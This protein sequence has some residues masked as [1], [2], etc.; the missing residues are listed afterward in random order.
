M[1]GGWGGRCRLAV[2]FAAV[3][4][5]GF[6]SA[7]SAR[8]NLD[9]ERALADVMMEPAEVGAPTFKPRDRDWAILPQ[10]GYSPEKGPNAGLK[11]V[12]R[13]L[14]AARL[15]LDI[16]GIYALKR[17]QKYELALVA[18]S[19]WKGR[20]I[21]I[22]QGQ[23]LFDP[24]KE[25]F[26]IGN[27]E[28]GPDPISTHEYQL[29]LGLVTLAARP[30]PRITFAL[31][32]GFNDVNVKPGELEDETPATTEVFPGLP[33]I[34]GGRTNPLAFSIVFN[35]REDVTRPTRGWSFTA[36]IQH[37]H[38]ELGN[39]FQFTRYILD[40]SYLRPL[41]TR[42]QVL[43]LRVAG[44]YIDAKKDEVPFYEFAALGGSADL[45]GYFHDRFLGTSR[46]MLNGEYRLKLFDFPFFDWWRVRID[47]VA[48]GDMGRVFSD[49]SE[50]RD[51][52]TVDG[53]LIP[54]VFRDFRYSYGGGARFALGDAIIARLDVGFSDEEDGLVYLTFGHTF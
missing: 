33:G 39:D 43:G 44:E 30:W 38:G 27:N 31:T 35:N 23:Y 28:V 42:R 6:V 22:V 54:R 52:F 1:R 4:V 17:Q 20:L 37:V 19:L 11:F 32:G 16:D 26:G 36:K 2:T 5:A 18:P 3:A 49:Q 34:H 51:E 50:F 14:T 13:D 41:L 15:T 7:T 10:I 8:E 40:A 48:F 46:V 29:V 45:R 24:T 53:D 25:F 9:T 47:G 21:G 12:D